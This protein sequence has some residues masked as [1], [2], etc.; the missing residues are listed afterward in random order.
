ML[1]YVDDLILLNASNKA[2]N[3]EIVTLKTLFDIDD[4][5]LVK[6][7]LGMKVC[8]SNGKI[9][10]TQPQLI[11]EIVSDTGIT[12]KDKPTATPAMSRKILRQFLREPPRDKELFHY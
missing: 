5:G 4:M 8:E 11:D 2:I 6:D 3:D 12:D 10:L 7:Y 1:M 9:S